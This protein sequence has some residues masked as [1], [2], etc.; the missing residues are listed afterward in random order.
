[1]Q[2]NLLYS[3]NKLYGKGNFTK[4]LGNWLYPDIWLLDKEKEQYST[5]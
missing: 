1:M 5:I 3:S 4:I 2:A